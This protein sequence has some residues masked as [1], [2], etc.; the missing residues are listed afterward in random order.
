MIILKNN[1]GGTMNHNFK[2]DYE[3]CT[4]CGLCI[5]NCPTNAL[6][7]DDYKS[8]KMNNPKNCMKCQHCFA[9]CPVGA[10]SI[11]DKNP[12]EAQM[13]REIN[14]EDVLNLIQSRRSIRKYKQENVNKE[15]I[16]KLKD[17]LNYVPTGKNN[18]KLH[19]SFIENIEVM[20]EFR[21]KVN[22]S[23]INFL[24]TKPVK[25]FSEKFKK[26]EGMKKTIEEGKDVIFRTAPHLVVVSAPITS[27]C[28]QQDGIIA[29]SYF[30][31]YA[32]SL[33]L[34]TCWC[35]YAQMILKTFPEFIEY[36]QIPQGHTPVYVMLFGY[37]DIKYTRTTKPNP[38]NFTTVEKQEI[39]VGF[40]T[41]LK[42]TFWNFIR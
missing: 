38:Y 1:F 34:G 4:K 5:E 27:P 12:A 7:P 16:Q 15:T 9:I 37:P 22:N 42:R 3:K 30:E 29:L 18:H 6:A 41:K 39:E 10:I 36:L 11:M 25:F 2:V 28:P 32:N 23:I 35:G 20:D 40:F 24:N 26:L 21:T 8:P 19:F 17:M 31:L 33:G 14:S 13:V